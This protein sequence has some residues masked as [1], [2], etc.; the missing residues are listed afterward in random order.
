MT[1]GHPAGGAGPELTVSMAAY[2]ARRHIGAAI[3]S[4][5][6][7]AGVG[8]EL[9]VVDDGS[10]DGT[11]D[12]VRAMRDPRLRLIRTGRHHGDAHCHNL[13][14]VG[15]TAAFVAHLRAQDVVLPGALPAL[16]GAARQT[17][18]VGFVH[19]YSFEIDEEGGITREAFRARR[20]L[21]LRTRP[22]GADYRR[23]LL[24]SELAVDPFRVYR[25]E[26][27]QAVGG[28]DD[29]CG[30]AAEY[31]VAL[32]IAD[33]FPIVLVPV[34]VCARRQSPSVARARGYAQALA[35]FARRLR[36]WHRLRSRDH[37]RFVHEPQYDPCRLLV[38]EGAIGIRAAGAAVRERGRQ[39]RRRW[40]PALSRRGRRLAE[41]FY[42]TLRP[43]LA[44]WPLLSA[45]RPGPAWRRPALASR[46]TPGTS[47]P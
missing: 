3:L 29:R 34:F 20:R 16:V 41:D 46:T 4:V 30:Y 1:A 35:R 17:P 40:W 7:Q 27:F 12:V 8:L 26:A 24:R 39:L 36:Y 23:E 21:L 31:D 9:V 11:A 2:N 6:G 38:R 18:D 44:W 19:G 13:A 33:H 43:R 47:P 42:E 37:I 45:G 32:K 22:P 25:R 28:L 10:G 5:L 15:S 14:T